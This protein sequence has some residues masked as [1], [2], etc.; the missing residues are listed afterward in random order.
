MILKLAE[1]YKKANFSKNLFGM[2]A[3]ILFDKKKIKFFFTVILKE[4]KNYFI[5]IMMEILLFLHL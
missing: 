3:I 4:R 2:F 5:T 1:K